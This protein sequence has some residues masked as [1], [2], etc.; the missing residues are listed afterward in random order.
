MRPRFHFTSQSGWINDPLG[1]TYDR[2]TYHLFFQYVPG[3]VTWD[4]RVHWGHATSSD[5][6]RWEERSVALA[7]DADDDGCWSGSVVVDDDGSATIFY[8]AVKVPD[9]AVGRVR[10]ARSSGG[11]WGGWTKG[12]VIVE[13]PPDVQA[14]AFRDP[15][16]FRDDAGV[17][18]SA[19]WRMLLGAG[20][21]DGTAAVLAYAST[22]LASWEYAGVLAERPGTLREPAWTGTIW[23]CPQFFPLGDRHVLVVSVWA[24]DVLHNVSYAVGDYRDGRFDAHTWRRLTYGPAYYAGAAFVDEHGERGLIS[25]LRG[26]ADPGGHWAGALSVPHLLRLDGDLVVAEP[27]PR[28]R[29]LRREPADESAA[30]GL[31]LEWTPPAGGSGRVVVTDDAGTPVVEVRVADGTL[32]VVGGHREPELMPYD[33]GPVRGLLDGP[34]LELFTSTGVLAASVPAMP[35]PG[36][37]AEGGELRWWRLA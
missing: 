17:A 3:Q 28:V 10:T 16:V 8:T 13:L 12:E 29:D 37:R 1:L 15:Y 9:V 14:L 2:G 7:P 32:A 35:R 21:S 6:L 23:E 11:D 34:V 22:D 18:G 33:G 4:P 36:I 30:S 20:L 5:L 26:I 24:D 31:D 19:G 25:W 27:H